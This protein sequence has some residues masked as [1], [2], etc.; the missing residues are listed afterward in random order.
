MANMAD[1]I[2]VRRA[3]PADAAGMARVHVAAW[4]ETY[5]GLM[6]DDVLDDPTFVDRRRGM[7]LRALTEER[8]AR[9]RVAVALRDG[10]VVGIAMAAEP[11]AE[12]VELTTLY[13]LAAEHGSG[14]GAR[15]LDA[16]LEPDE[17][18]ALWVA[19]P[20]PRAQAFYRRH[21]FRPDGAE[22]V[23]DGVPAIHMVRATGA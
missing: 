22:R 20:N 15:L 2:E 8:F 10:Q 23:D 3:Q 19:D 16:V 17:P 7:W 4:R 9:H 1:E 11:G 6:T 5:R 21:G 14:A 12:G 13:L 18:A